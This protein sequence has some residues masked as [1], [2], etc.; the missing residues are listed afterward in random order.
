MGWGM[1]SEVRSVLSVVCC[2]LTEVRSVLSVVCCL[3]TEVG[4]RKEVSS[5]KV[6]GLYSLFF[7]LDSWFLVLGSLFLVLLSDVCCLAIVP[8]LITD[9]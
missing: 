7:R 5:L 9:N 1:W 8:I 4:S 2:L 6:F 3:L